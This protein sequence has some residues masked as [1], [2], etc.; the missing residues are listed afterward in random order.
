MLKFRKINTSI[1]LKTQARLRAA[2]INSIIDKLN[3]GCNAARDS[4][5][6]ENGSPQFY[7]IL[8]KYLNNPLSVALGVLVLISALIFAAAWA[9]QSDFLTSGESYFEAQRIDIPG[10]NGEFEGRIPYSEL[11]FIVKWVGIILFLSFVR[12]LALTIFGET[13]RPFRKNLRLTARSVLPMIII[14]G[15]IAVVNHLW[16]MVPADSISQVEPG[17][18]MRVVAT[19][20]F[21]FLGWLAEGAITVRGYRTVFA[22]TTSN[23]N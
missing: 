9:A 18:L 16:P 6:F 7:R 3:S 20:L 13:E 8:M 21:V 14:G 15:A 5:N 23:A 10:N 22:L 12:N 2:A 19:A 4:R 17:Q 11:L 1:V